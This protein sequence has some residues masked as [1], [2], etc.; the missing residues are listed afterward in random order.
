MKTLH[1]NL[2]KEWFNLIVLGIK[3]EEYREIKEHWVSQFLTP[4]I[5]KELYGSRYDSVRSIFNVL[6][7]YNG[8]RYLAVE[9]GINES[10]FNFNKFDTVTFSNGYAKERPQF[11]I[12]FKGFEIKEG[13]KEWGAEIGR[14]YFVLKLGEIIHLGNKNIDVS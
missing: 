2:K 12:E 3:K 7:G 8:K 10:Y 9:H 13:K 5:K 14:K 4:T 6:T 11:E 1:L